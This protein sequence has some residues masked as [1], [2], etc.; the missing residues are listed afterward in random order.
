M[1]QRLAIA[2]RSITA[3]SIVLLGGCQ[4]QV[5]SLLY[6]EPNFNTQLLLAYLQSRTGEMA[7][8][9][10]A[11][12]AD[13]LNL[14]PQTIPDECRIPY[15]ADTPQVK[16]CVY[17]LKG[18]IDDQY[19]EYRITL[20]HLADGG[21]ALADTIVLGVNTAGTAVVGAAAKT[22]L[23]AIG[24]GVGGTKSIFNE[25][26]LYKQT[27]ITVLNQ[28]DADRDKQFSM[29]LEEMK[30]LTPY[31]LAQAKDDL[32][33]YF[34]YGTFDHGIS[35][36]QAATAANKEKC[37]KQLDTTK[38]AASNGSAGSVTTTK[39]VTTKATSKNATTT[40]TTKDSST[41]ANGC[42]DTTTGE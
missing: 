4:S 34:E 16:L 42:A 37:K 21:N 35:S 28:M 2:A 15:N 14:Q 40:T 33:L 7:P 13:A 30:G 12:A 10:G 20:H 22:I 19:R 17:A 11:R 31:T 38:I 24:A 26:L 5:Q 36:L 18:L 3:A 27:I 8:V 39:T 32:L 23:A 25:D 9:Q 6:G 41:S 29:M 1:W